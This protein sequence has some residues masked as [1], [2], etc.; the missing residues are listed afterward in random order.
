MP[1]IRDIIQSSPLL[2]LLTLWCPKEHMSYYIYFAL[3]LEPVRCLFIVQWIAYIHRKAQQM[4]VEWNWILLTRSIY[5]LLS[6][7]QVKIFCSTRISSFTSVPLPPQ[8]LIVF[9]NCVMAVMNLSPS[10]LLSLSL[11]PS[12]SASAW[13]LL[14]NW[15]CKLAV[16]SNGWGNSVWMFKWCT[17]FEGIEVCTSK[18]ALADTLNPDCTTD[19]VVVYTF[20]AFLPLK[21]WI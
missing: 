16:W 4:L 7:I 6:R 14:T 2:L 9:Q 8:I 20:S 12:L 21:W 3:Y 17:P 5:Q 11:S 15:L 19:T 13:L 10:P 1:Y 18:P